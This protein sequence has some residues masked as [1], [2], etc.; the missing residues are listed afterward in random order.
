MGWAP[1]V[2]A[3]HESVDAY[4]DMHAHHL[5]PLCVYPT[6]SRSQED[7]SLPVGCA[8]VAR[9]GEMMAQSIGERYSNSG[10]L[11]CDGAMPCSLWTGRRQRGAVVFREEI[12]TG[13]HPAS[14]EGQQVSPAPPCPSSGSAPQFRHG[15][16]ADDLMFNRS[17]LHIL[18]PVQLEVGDRPPC[19]AQMRC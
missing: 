15:N 10:G 13:A 3:L 9:S 8:S 5:H 1:A 14:A 4:A 17:D 18:A 16:T 6:A 7:E 11:S 12:P 19:C 2:G